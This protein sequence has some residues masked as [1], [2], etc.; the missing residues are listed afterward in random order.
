[1]CRNRALNGDRE[2]ENSPWDKKQRESEAMR[3]QV[4]GADWTRFRKLPGAIEVDFHWSESGREW[5]PYDQ[6]MAEVCDEALNALKRTQENGTRYIIFMH[7][8]STSRLG[9]TTARSVV[10]G[11]MRSSAATPYIVRRECIQ[12]DTVFVVAIRTK[13][14]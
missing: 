8:S 2:A 9:K 6:K 7:G 5:R 1:M 10:R 11:L 13:R 3:W 14:R 4:E 12:H